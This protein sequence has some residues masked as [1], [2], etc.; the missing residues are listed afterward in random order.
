MPPS[1]HR[2]D[3]I[4]DN[5]AIRARCERSLGHQDARGFARFELEHAAAKRMTLELPTQLGKGQPPTAL[6]PGHGLTVP[7]SDH[8]DRIR[9]NATGVVR[10]ESHR[11]RTKA[12][13]YP[14]APPAA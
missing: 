14:G 6:Q 3:S 8:V 13:V 7:N 11:N 2:V 12:I 5:F 10:Y 9:R 1:L 4:A